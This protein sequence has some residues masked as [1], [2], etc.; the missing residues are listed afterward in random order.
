MFD[1]AIFSKRVA[2]LR[3][4]HGISQTELGAV[5]GVSYF[6]IGK[7]EKGERA[8]SI[9]VLCALADYFNVSLDYLCGRTDDPAF[10]PAAGRR[11][12][13]RKDT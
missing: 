2:A 4:A 6:A 11:L 3:K 7:I 1:K 9:E 12:N 8:A 10:S 13:E 5:A